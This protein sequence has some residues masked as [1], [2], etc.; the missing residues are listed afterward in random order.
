MIK[1]KHIL[2]LLFLLWIFVFGFFNGQ[3]FNNDTVTRDYGTILILNIILIAVIL[4]VKKIQ[5]KTR[6]PNFKWYYL[7][8]FSVVVSVAFRTPFGFNINNSFNM[9]FTQLL[10]LGLSAITWRVSLKKVL[11]VM[12]LFIH[13][14]LMLCLYVHIKTGGTFEFGNHTMAGRLGGLFFFADTAALAGFGLNIA[15]YLWMKYRTKVSIVSGGVFL[16]F[17]IIGDSRAV[18]GGVLLAFIVQ[19][20]FYLKAKR[21]STKKLII[22]SLVT[23]PLYNLYKS[24]NSGGA[25]VEGD[26]EFRTQIWSVAFVGIKNKLWT[27][28]GDSKYYFSTIT[29]HITDFYEQL[30]DPHSSYLAFVLQYG[31]IA[32]VVFIIFLVKTIKYVY[33]YVNPIDKGVTSFIFFWIVI[34]LTGGTIFN[35]N[36][37]LLSLLFQ[38]SIFGICLH[39]NIRTNI[40]K[41]KDESLVAKKYNENESVQSLLIKNY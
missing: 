26:F 12:L 23:I 28:Y 24:L 25:D 22:I 39:P 36:Y 10:I 38:F 2:L 33:K 9:L 29:T 8:L 20:Y 15:F 19:Y 3:R 17:L 1:L 5:F 27:G 37:T 35:F 4:F 11:D 32:F 18:M 7:M 40:L 6:F 13:I 41:L 16:F 31:V 34:G 30:S 14:A 21:K